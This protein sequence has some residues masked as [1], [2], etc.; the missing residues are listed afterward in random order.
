MYEIKLKDGDSKKRFLAEIYSNG[1]V[2]ARI[3]FGAKNGST[4]IDHND[5]IK[6]KNYIARHSALN[7]NWNQ[8]N[9]GSLSRYLL[10][11]KKSL[12]EAKKFYEKKF[13]VSFTK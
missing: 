4:Y 13:H 6:K 5:D 11:E 2:V 8:I 10:W 7:E 1:V 12:D 9:S 3:K